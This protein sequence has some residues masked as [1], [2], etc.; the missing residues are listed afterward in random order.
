[1][2]IAIAN[3]RIVEQLRRLVLSA[4][5]CEVAWIARNGSEAVEKCALDP[6]DLVLMEPNLPMLNGVEATRRI[7]RDFP[8]PI[9]IVTDTVDGNA[10]KVFEAMGYGALDAVSAPMIGDDVVVE[11]SQ[12]LLLKKIKM[13][14]RLR[15]TP[16]DIIQPESGHAKHGRITVS[17][18]VAIGASAGGPKTLAKLLAQFPARLSAIIII[19]QHVDQEFSAG[20]VEWLAVQTPLKVRLAHEGEQPKSGHVY[21]AGT[22]HHLILT[23]GLRFAYTP[24][25]HQILYRPSVDVF[26][27]S[28]ARYWPRKGCA[29]LLTG[30]GRDGAK[31]LASLHNVGWYTIAQDEATSIVYGMPKAAKELGAATNILPI[32]EIGPRV[33]K[34]LHQGLK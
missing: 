25:P 7:M 8:C 19:I 5:D 30:M 26:F 18:M 6:P 12:T 4:P 15:K 10:A 22:N 9:L 11:N 14:Q 24:E 20:L 34:I 28:A 1:M 33:L 3:H 31:G 16:S 23:P 32:D 21:V 27:E 29:I 17:P 13:I 2:R